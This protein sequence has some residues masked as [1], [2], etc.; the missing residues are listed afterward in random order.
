MRKVV[1]VGYED[2]EWGEGW[3]EVYV[4]GKPV[5]EKICD[6]HMDIGDCSMEPLWEALG[7]QVEFIEV[8]DILQ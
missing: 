6:K 2:E 4:D 8:E 3:Y 5:I 1:F 7:F